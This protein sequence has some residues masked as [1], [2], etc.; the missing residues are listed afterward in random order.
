MKLTR[1]RD[2]IW[3]ALH[4]IQRWLLQNFI[5]SRRSEH[6]AKPVKIPLAF[7]IHTLN[8]WRAE[9]SHSLIVASK[10]DKD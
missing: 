5:L 7:V 4:K 9:H 10:A 3:T 6:D 1:S 2:Q 8:R